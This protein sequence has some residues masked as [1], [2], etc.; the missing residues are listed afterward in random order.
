MPDSPTE[1]LVVGAGPTGLVLALWLHRLGV[2]VQRSTELLGFE[3][4][5]GQLVARLRG[6][7]GTERTWQGQYLAGCDG[8]HSKTREVLG[9]NFPGGTYERVFYV[10]DAV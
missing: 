2:K 6:P 8:A 3:E 10:A 7:D 1:V 9:Y 5:D 4:Q